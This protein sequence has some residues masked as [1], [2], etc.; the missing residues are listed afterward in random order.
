MLEV[1]LD[2]VTVLLDR[3]RL[4]NWWDCTKNIIIIYTVALKAVWKPILSFCLAD[5]TV[6][7]GGLELSQKGRP[8]L[9]DHEPTHEFA[10]AT[11][12][13]SIF[14]PRPNLESLRE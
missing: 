13:I 1:G 4:W 10:S 12:R 7:I 11:P 9:S 6:P 8:L 5:A 14:P 2:A 3:L